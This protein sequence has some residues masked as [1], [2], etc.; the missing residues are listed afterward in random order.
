M[1]RIHARDYAPGANIPGEV[2]LAGEFGVARA[3]V[4][5]ALREL[6]DEGILER[7]RNS[8]TRVAASC[9]LTS[10]AM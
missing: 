8:G 10:T 5:R 7:R 6:S 1:R 9:A 2:E 3:T 4:N